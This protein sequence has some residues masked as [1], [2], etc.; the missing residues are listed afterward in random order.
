MKKEEI[1]SHIGKPILNPL[2]NL[3]MLCLIGIASSPFIWIWFGFWLA[4]KIFMSCILGALLFTWL[5]KAVERICKEVV[6]KE[7][8]SKPN[9]NGKSKF[10]EKLSYLIEQQ[11]QAK[12]Q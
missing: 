10:Q 11:K 7:M 1:V 2:G 12:E 3:V 8:E 4:F 5:Y 6:D 9:L